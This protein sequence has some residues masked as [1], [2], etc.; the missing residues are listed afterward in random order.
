MYSCVIWIFWIVFVHEGF[1]KEVPQEKHCEQKYESPLEVNKSYF[2]GCFIKTSYIIHKIQTLCKSKYPYIKLPSNDLHA[3]DLRAG[4][5]DNLYVSMS[6]TPMIGNHL[7]RKQRGRLHRLLY[8]SVLFR[9]V[10]TEIWCLFLYIYTFPCF[11]SILFVYWNNRWKTRL[12]ST[13]WR[14]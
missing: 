11:E 12:L 13:N 9:Y 2:Q 10:I 7:K 5:G 14:G 8:L 1:S 4:Q 6:C 3:Y